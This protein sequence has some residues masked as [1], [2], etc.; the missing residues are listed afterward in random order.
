VRRER[1]AAFR[2][3][4]VIVAPGE[5]H[6]LN[7]VVETE[8]PLGGFRKRLDPMYEFHTRRRIGVHHIPRRRDDERDYLRWCFADRV[9]AEAFAAEFSGTLVLPK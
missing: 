7:E 9:T 5:P 6:I 1:H 3:A 4:A 8:I 2:F